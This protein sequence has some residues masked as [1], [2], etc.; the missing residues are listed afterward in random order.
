MLYA[1]LLAV[2]VDVVDVAIDIYIDVP[3]VLSISQLC[4]V[5]K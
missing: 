2:D 1:V 4:T 3:V 5:E